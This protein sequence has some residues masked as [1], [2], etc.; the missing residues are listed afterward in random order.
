MDL[1]TLENILFMKIENFLPVKSNLE[2]VVVI[3][4]FLATTSMDPALD[5]NKTT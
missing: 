3:K 2:K 4:I 5:A 1:Q